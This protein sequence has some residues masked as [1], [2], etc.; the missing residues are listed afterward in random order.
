MGQM[1]HGQKKG[2]PVF[3]ASHVGGV[4]GCFIVFYVCLEGRKQK[5]ENEQRNIRI[6]GLGLDIGPDRKNH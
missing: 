3:F 6:L 1:G 2:S 5:A 4:L